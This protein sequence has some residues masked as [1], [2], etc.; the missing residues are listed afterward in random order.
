MNKIVTKFLCIFFSVFFV[1]C[2]A[3]SA[4]AFALDP[5]N[6]YRWNENGVRYFSTTFTGASSIRTYDYDLLLIG[7]S[8]VQN[9]DAADFAENMHCKPLKVTVGAMTPK[10]IAWVYTC[11]NEQNKATD[12]IINLDLHRFATE[13]SCVPDAGRFHKEMYEASGIS[14]FKY[15]LGFETWFRFI[16]VNAALNIV[17]ALNIPLPDS[18]YE[19]L[20]N[21][22]DINKMCEFENKK[23]PGEKSLIEKYLND[24]KGFNEGEETEFNA[25]CQNAMA[26]FLDLIAEEIDGNE[27]VTLLLPP[28]SSLYWCDKSENEL[29]TLLNLRNQVAEFAAENEK[30]RLIDFQGEA[31]TAD[32]N[33]YMDMSHF[34]DDIQQAMADEIFDTAVNTTPEQVAANS[35]EIIF[36]RNEIKEKLQ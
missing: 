21:Q 12:Y 6:V 4:V 30:V 18:F 13:S 19:L 10:E 8:M 28:Y 17:S 16:P 20:E 11:A 22:T 24:D 25:D 5:H 1:I 3:F 34:S 35:K 26:E 15:L 27:T 31:Y 29:Q 36:Y 9:F 14:Q 32:L 7:S 33:N 23:T 2:G